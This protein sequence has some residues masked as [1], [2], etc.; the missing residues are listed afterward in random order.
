MPE[1]RAP[2]QSRARVTYPKK[3]R[4]SIRSKPNCENKE[5]INTKQFYIDRYRQASSSGPDSRFRWI[6]IL[7][8]STPRSE[9]PLAYLNAERGA[10]NDIYTHKGS[11]NCGIGRAMLLLCLNDDDIIGNGGYNPLDDP[12]EDEDLGESARE[13]CKAIVLL[14]CAPYESTLPIACK[15]YMDTAKMA[16]Y[17][18]VF[19]QKDYDTTYKR[20]KIEIAKSIFENDPEDF[21]DEKGQHWFFCKCRPNKLQDCKGI[22]IFLLFYIMEM[23]IYVNLRE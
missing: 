20:L 23:C 21:L 2:Y 17:H 16:G 4:F 1:L 14:S 19:I 18:L 12:W 8:P 9:T 6:A 15:M 22:L 7:N 10:C 5:I 11:K 13:L 3:E